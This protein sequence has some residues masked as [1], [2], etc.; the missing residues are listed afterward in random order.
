[1][2]EVELLR[3][4]LR[5]ALQERD[6]YRSETAKFRTENAKLQNDIDALFAQLSDLDG[7]RKMEEVSGQPSAGNNANAVAGAVVKADPDVP[8]PEVI[9]LRSEDGQPAAVPAKVCPTHH[10]HNVAT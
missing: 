2:S 6:H 3:E 5:K 8:N 9:D 1:M 10:T 7:L 4:S